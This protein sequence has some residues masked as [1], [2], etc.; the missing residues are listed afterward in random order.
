MNMQSARISIAATLLTAAL[1]SI[2]ACGKRVSA[3]TDDVT[4]TTRVKT[5]L[6][7]APDVDGL[8]IDVSTNQ[9]VVT[10]SGRVAS[11]AARD[12]AIDIAR[13]TAGVVEVRSTLEVGAGG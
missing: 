8:G 11:T 10:L 3:D 6:L 7:N 1:L 2:P 5:A 13:D 12:R 4:I 9:R